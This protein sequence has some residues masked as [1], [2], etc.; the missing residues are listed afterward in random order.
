MV[1]KKSTG[2]R[3]SSRGN[4]KKQQGGTLLDQMAQ[5]TD[6]QTIL[7]NENTRQQ[8]CFEQ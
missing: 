8:Y 7:D 3:K 5:D 4:K 1:K 6:K 2:K